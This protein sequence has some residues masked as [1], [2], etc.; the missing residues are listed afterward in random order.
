MDGTLELNHTFGKVFTRV[1]G[2]AT[3]TKN[4]IL[5]QDEPDYMY[6]YQNHTGKKLG[7]NFGL[8]ALGYF[9]DEDEV[10]NSPK[11]TFT[12]NVRPGDIKYLDVNADGQIDTYDEVAIGYSDIPELVYGFGFQLG[13]KGFD[14]GVFFRG[15]GRVSYMLGGE[16][17]VPFEQGGTRGNLFEE[18]LDRWTPDNPNPNAFYPRLDIG[19][20]ENNYRNSTHWLYNGSFLR[21]ADLEFGYSFSKR[22]ISPL[23]LSGLRLYFHGSNLLLFS[24]FKMW[25]PEIGKGRGDAY[26]MQRKMNIGLRVNF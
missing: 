8:I 16:G 1:Y 14:L 9:K 22:M 19:K 20:N 2:N 13:Y 12:P 15:Q 6:S 24:G 10:K 17:F 23:R 3:F 7:Q 25:D 11:Q 5:E 18:A 4:K 21:L 26:P